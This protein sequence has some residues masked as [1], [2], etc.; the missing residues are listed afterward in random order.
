[1]T[2]YIVQEIELMADG[3]FRTAIT[4]HVFKMLQTETE[5]D[6]RLAGLVIS[7]WNQIMDFLKQIAMLQTVTT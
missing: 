4:C 1:M 6:T 3:E 5:S 2:F 7:N